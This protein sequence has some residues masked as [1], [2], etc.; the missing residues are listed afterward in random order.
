MFAS[1]DSHSMPVR[2]FDVTKE[3]ADWPTKCAFYGLP[4]APTLPCVV[5][6][7]CGRCCLPLHYAP[8][9]PDGAGFL[10]AFRA[11]YAEYE[12]TSGRFTEA[13]SLLACH[14]FPS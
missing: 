4:A 5:F 14:Q 9:G 1:D 6:Y 11:A 13:L 2:A 3:A 7:G 10:A 8:L 12:T